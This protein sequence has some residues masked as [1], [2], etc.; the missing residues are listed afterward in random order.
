MA[1]APSRADAAPEMAGR[2]RGRSWWF[3]IPPPRWFANW[4]SRNQDP[5]LP[6]SVVAPGVKE[7]GHPTWRPASDQPVTDV[8]LTISAEAPGRLPTLDPAGPHGRGFVERHLV[9][10]RR[11]LQ[12]HHAQIARLARYA[13]TSGVAFGV[14]ELTLLVLYGYGVVSATVAALIANLAGTVPSYLMSRYWIW[15]EAARTRVVRQVILYWA[16]S[17]SCIVLTSLATGAIA[18]LAPAGHRFHL[19]VVAIGFPAVTLA[20]WLLKFV[21]YQRVIFPTTRRRLG[22]T[23]PR[24]RCRRADQAARSVPAVVLSVRAATGRVVR[25]RRPTDGQPTASDCSPSDR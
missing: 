13:A 14:S 6:P 16:T 5:V 25:S 11:A 19:A 21:L 24:D 23:W 18:T 20:F 3:P 1:T 7:S 22:S 4:P 10:A 12:L 17:V 9:V 15:K 2:V 8:G